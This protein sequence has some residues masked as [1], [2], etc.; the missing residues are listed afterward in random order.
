[1]ENLKLII[2]SFINSNIDSIKS[3]L[4]VDAEFVETYIKSELKKWSKF[5]SKN[6]EIEDLYYNYRLGADVISILNSDKFYYNLPFSNYPTLFNVVN[7][8][9]KRV[10][11]T[12]K[13]L[14]SKP[15]VPVKK[16]YSNIDLNELEMPP[17][18][19][20]QFQEIP[21]IRKM[22]T[23]RFID[24]ACFMELKKHITKNGLKNIDGVT[25]SVVDRKDCV[26]DSSS[27]FLEKK[28]NFNHFPLEQVYKY[29][30]QLA[31]SPEDGSKHLEP[32][33][34]QSEVLEFI[35]R[36]FCNSN[37]INKLTFRN[38]HRKQYLIW[39]LFYNFFKDSKYS[40]YSK[41]YSHNKK[42]YVMLITSNFDN[43][44]YKI[45]HDN[46][47]TATSKQWKSINDYK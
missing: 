1:M 8:R 26:V 4:N 32:F 44:D 5:I 46:F 25:S 40:K 43:W 19:E 23:E 18:F 14:K 10:A 28:N 2:N 27:Y 38:T 47:S 16:K 13:N 17:E 35:D 42:K 24:Y 22:L 20:I 39:K 34:N 11:S 36:A 7:K 33:L 3:R 21:K 15:L 31:D 6:S 29:F 12:D 45:V 41:L 37:T 30:M 9:K